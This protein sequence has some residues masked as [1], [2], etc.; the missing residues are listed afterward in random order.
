MI[1]FAVLHQ[2]GRHL[3]SSIVAGFRFKACRRADIAG[4]ER[5]K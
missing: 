5:S 4:L 3:S 1:M 2:Q